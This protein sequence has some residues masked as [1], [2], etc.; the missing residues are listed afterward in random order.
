MDGKE[1]FTVYRLPR[2]R[3]R[4]GRHHPR[5]FRTRIP[6]ARPS[7]SSVRIEGFAMRCKLGQAPASSLHHPC[8]LAS[9][10]SPAGLEAGYLPWMHTTGRVPN[11]SLNCHS[12]HPP[13]Q[14][15]GGNLGARG[16]CLANGLAPSRSGRIAHRDLEAAW[17]ND[18]RNK[19]TGRGNAGLLCQPAIATA[20]IGPLTTRSMELRMGPAWTPKHLQGCSR[21][22]PQT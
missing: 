9:L 5:L 17:A 22:S 8:R 20:T 12:I 7:G 3:W 13:C 4:F 14:G 6:V 21:R 1:T 11:P 15:G 10:A 19:R 2:G 18:L 16:K